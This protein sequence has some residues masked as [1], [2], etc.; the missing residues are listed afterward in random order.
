MVGLHDQGEVEQ[1]VIRPRQT[2]LRYTW[3]IAVW[4]PAFTQFMHEHLAVCKSSAANQPEPSVGNVVQAAIHNN[5]RVEGLPISTDP[6]LDIGTP[7][8]LVKA[9]KHFTEPPI[10]DRQALG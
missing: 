3:G 5:L 10:A 7:E 6:Y 1:I 2:Q 4:T 9:V 8:D